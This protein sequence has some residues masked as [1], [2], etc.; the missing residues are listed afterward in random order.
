MSQMIFAPDTAA[1]LEFTAALINTGVDAT[2]SLAATSALAGLLDAFAF[3]GTRA[4]TDGELEAVRTTR[5]ELDAMWR[6]EV[7]DGVAMTN[8]MLHRYQALPQLVTHP[9]NPEW[10]IHATVPADPLHKRIAVEA[11]LA[12]VD[13]YRTGEEDRIKVCAGGGCTAVVLDLS[14]NRSKRFCDTGNCANREHV[15]AYRRRQAG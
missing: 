2:E 4:G 5:G 9:E 12:F 6:A 14:R 15:A 10:H 1:A 11:A 3:T 8:E 13:V 7:P